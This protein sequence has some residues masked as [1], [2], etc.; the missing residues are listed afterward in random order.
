[1]RGAC[2][3]H[4]AFAWGSHHRRCAQLDL[5]TVIDTNAVR[6]D[7][8]GKLAR[9]PVV[10]LSVWHL[11]D[12]EVS[13]VDAALDDRLCCDQE[14]IPVGTGACAF[15][16]ARSETPEP[17]AGTSDVRDIDAAILQAAHERKSGRSI[18]RGRFFVFFREPKRCTLR[19][20]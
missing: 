11:H 9:R 1:M 8:G 15:R 13:G 4:G 16:S 19:R 2:S 17:A 12:I 5:S 3:D 18:H 14:D 6:Y 7:V 10:K 20:R